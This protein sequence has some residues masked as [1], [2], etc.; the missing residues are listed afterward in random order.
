MASYTGWR[1]TRAGIIYLIVAVLLAVAVFLTAWWVSQRGEQARRDQAV[2]IAQENIDADD[3]AT[4]GGSSADGDESSNGAAS[5]DSNGDEDSTA[6]GDANGSGG[7]EGTAGGAS[8]ESGDSLA[9]T[10]VNGSSSGSSGGGSPAAELPATGPETTVFGA[11]I[12]ALL[13]F[14]TA[15]YLVSHRAARQL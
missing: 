7:D 3:A 15:T 13:G 10:G 1:P 9:A 4:D 8:D 6:D 11:L 2:Q 12:I 14:M 5:G